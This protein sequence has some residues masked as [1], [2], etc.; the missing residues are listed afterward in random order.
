MNTLRQIPKVE[1]IDFYDEDMN[2][3]LG[4]IVTIGLDDYKIVPPRNL[5]SLCEG[6][7]FKINGICEAPAYAPCAQ[8]S[9][10]YIKVTE[11][12]RPERPKRTIWG[13]IKWII[14]N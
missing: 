2:Y 11:K 1:I 3:T 12:Y 4:S 9:R 10:I 7:D 6:C 5:N 14:T 13:F 8:P